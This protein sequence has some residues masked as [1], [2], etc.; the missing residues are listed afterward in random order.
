MRRR[1]PLNYR[2]PPGMVQVALPAC[3]AD[4][5]NNACPLE[6]FLK[7]AKAAVDPGCVTA[8]AGNY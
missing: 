4:Q 2:D 7:I 3:S 8:M 6:T 5:V 1:A